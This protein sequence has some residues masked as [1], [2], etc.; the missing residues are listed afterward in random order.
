MAKVTKEYLEKAG[1]IRGGVITGLAGKNPSLQMLQSMLMSGT[2]LAKVALQEVSYRIDEYSRDSDRVY[3]NGNTER[4]FDWLDLAAYYI[5]EVNE[6]RVLRDKYLH[7]WSKNTKPSKG[8][9]TTEFYTFQKYLEDGT[10]EE[11][12]VSVTT[13]EK[14]K[15]YS[16]YRLIKIGDDYSYAYHTVFDDVQET[17]KSHIS[18]IMPNIKSW[19]EYNKN[20]K[21]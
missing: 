17:I 4:N 9:E 7:S 2:G 16:S 19:E 11:V 12:P 3:D 21:K 20:K 6:L 18:E 8:V 5:R 15:Y 14:G 1:Y 10:Q 13:Y